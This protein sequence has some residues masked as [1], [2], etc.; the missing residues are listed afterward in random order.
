MTNDTRPDHVIAKEELE[1]FV[2]SLGLKAE[3]SSAVGH[4]KTKKGA[5]AW[6]CLQ[7]VMAVKGKNFKYSVGLGLAKLPDIVAVLSSNSA[8]SFGLTDGQC[9]AI[10]TYVRNPGCKFCDAKAYANLIDGV[11]ILT[12]RAKRQP[13][14]ADILA[15]VTRDSEALDMTFDDWC[16]NCG[17]DADSREAE[18]VYN[19]CCDNARKLLAF[20]SRKQIST[21]YDFAN[22][23]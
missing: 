2:A 23:L 22:R 16:D 1:T 11:A 8:W 7:Y 5:D 21:I 18:K 4:V 10:R 15:A 20:L 14:V 3:V 19:A 17:Y 13:T 12:N 9:A 6:P